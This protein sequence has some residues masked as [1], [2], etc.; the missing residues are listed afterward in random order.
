MKHLETFLRD[1]T[2]KNIRFVSNLSED[3][4]KMAADES[5]VCSVAAGGNHFPT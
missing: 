4:W 3:G 1:K 2:T 5:Q